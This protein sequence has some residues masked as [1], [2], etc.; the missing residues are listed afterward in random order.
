MKIES[1]NLEVSRAS[2]RNKNWKTV[3][4][5]PEKF[6]N[7]TRDLPEK[8]SLTT[9]FALR[10]SEFPASLPREVISPES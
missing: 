2:S 7:R 8:K 6:W 5:L 4:D 3:L 1:K 9:N 10:E